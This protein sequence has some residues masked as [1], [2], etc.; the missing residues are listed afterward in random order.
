ELCLI[1]SEILKVEKIGI[2]DNFFNLGGDSIKGIQVISLAQKK[3]IFFSI[4]DLFK[5]PTI[6]ELSSIS[7]FEECFQGR[8]LQSFSLISS[9]D[10]LKMPKY[11]EDAYPLTALQAGMLFHT[12]LQPEESIYQD[13]FLYKIQGKYYSKAFLTAIKTLTQYH[14][15]LRTS[16]EFTTYTQP[17]QLVHPSCSIPVY[18]ENICHLSETE[19][20]VFVEQWLEQEKKQKFFWNCPPLLRL[21]LIRSHTDIFYIGVTFHHA[22][23]DGWSFASLMMELIETYGKILEKQPLRRENEKTKFNQYILLE[24]EAIQ[25]KEQEQFWK[26]YLNDSSY[27]SLPKIKETSKAVERKGTIENYNV[28]LPFSSET[29]SCFARK[30]QVPVKILFLAA[31]FR[32][33]AL[34]SGKYD[35]VTGYVVNGRPEVLESE[36]TLGLFLNTLPLRLFLSGGTWEDL[37]KITLACTRE[38]LPYRRYPLFKMQQHQSHSLFEVTFN[39]VN[40]HIYESIVKSKHL[41][42]LNIHAYE[43]TNFYFCANASTDPLTLKHRLDLQ[44]DPSIL[45]QEQVEMIGEYYRS[46][47]KQMIVA[48]LSRYDHFSILSD[49]EQHHLLIDWNDTKTDFPEDKTIY[50]LFEEQVKKNPHNTAVIY[51]N[52]SLTYQQLNERANQ[53]ARYLRSLGVN[54]D[55]IV[56]IAVER[57]LEMIVGLLG[58]LKA[59]GAYVPL[60][61]FYPQDRLQFIL[62]DTNAPIIITDLKTLDKLPSTWAQIICLEERWDSIKSFSSA[63]LNHSTF[64]HNLAYVIYTSGSTG[65]PKGVMIGQRNL[66]HYINY[67]QKTYPLSKGNSLLHS[68]IAFDMS[69]TSLFLP[70]TTGNVILISPQ[71]YQIDSLDEIFSKYDNNLSFIKITPAHLKILKNNKNLKFMHEQKGSVIVGGDIFLQEDAKFWLEASPNICLFNEYGPTE[72]TVGC[73]VL[74][75]EDSHVLALGSASIGRPIFNTQIY[76]LD[77]CL[78]LVPVGVS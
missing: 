60:D 8:K 31:H 25:S 67:S 36:K 51:E 73:S 44:Y 41:Q 57:S 35:V 38:I 49:K 70:L 55:T 12:Q 50:Q 71:N 46:I 45:T 53:L 66:T 77:P 3:S 34:L 75:L 59:G 28:D 15:I 43:Q 48:P 56:A 68:S 2:H 62:E 7:K 26:A 65:R 10:R 14:P 5:H 27:L 33:L 23:L 52:Q 42:I 1:W 74:R 13:T 4:A 39:Y 61:P 19:Q 20:N 58:I 16:F 29:L 11:I 54:P 24:Q 76:L 47:L 69:I 63:N 17:L 30:F 40:F 64:P 72:A 78:N 6:I 37:I 18:F 32:T 9:E 22:I 21:T